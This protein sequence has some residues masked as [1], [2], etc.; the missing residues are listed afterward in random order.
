[1]LWPWETSFP[2][3]YTSGVLQGTVDNNGAIFKGKKIV[4]VLMD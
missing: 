2:K 3:L 1:M 4:L